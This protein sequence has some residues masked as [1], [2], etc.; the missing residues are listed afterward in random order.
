LQA[1]AGAAA[2]IFQRAVA[3]AAA[4]PEGL[5]LAVEVAGPDADPVV[6]P[7]VLDRF[8][9][10]PLDGKVGASLWRD[11]SAPWSPGEIQRVVVR[12]K[13][14]RPPIHA[15]VD[16]DGF[17]D[18]DGPILRQ[19]G[20]AIAQA[21]EAMRS[22]D[23]ERRI[24]L[25]L[26]RSF[27]PQ[28]LP[29][30]AGID[31]AVRYSPA[32][33][34]A[35]VGGDFYETV[36]IDG[37]LIAAIGDVAGHSLHA[38]TVMAELRHALR[39]F[40]AEGHDP[41]ATLVRLNNLMLRFLPDEIATMCLV[42]LDPAS[43]EVW[44]ANAGHPAPLLVRDGKVRLIEQRYPLLGVP[45]QRGEPARFTLEA[46]DTL[47]FVTDGLI[48]RR[49]H[50]IDEGVALLCAA[51]AVVEPDLGDFCDRLLHELDGL[52]REDDVALLVIRRVALD[53]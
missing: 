22:Y 39:A 42:R 50:S 10:D 23:E 46:G 17:Q 8:A 29:R 13:E 21:V 12:S 38:A 20:H 35:E 3:V 15:A 40:I 9:E 4:P 24:A 48:K 16:A 53:G 31:L 34:H 41:S 44:L 25:T 52:S 19:L 51:A 2:R 49:G 43:G 1:A 18:D 45:G 14:G 26:Q 32:S 11:G 27:L 33:E 37:Q 47:V 7:A 6:R 36:A 5:P 28:H 30:V